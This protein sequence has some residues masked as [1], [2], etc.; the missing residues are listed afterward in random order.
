MKKFK[1]FEAAVT[2][3]GRQDEE[4]DVRS[5]KASAVM[6]ALHHS[7]VLQPERSRKA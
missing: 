5:R 6:R 3:D 1:Y 4:L 2:N 7:V